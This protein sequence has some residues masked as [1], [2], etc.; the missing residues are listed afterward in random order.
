MPRML[1]ARRAVPRLPATR[2]PIDR[3]VWVVSRLQAGEPLN[4]TRV[5]ERF[6]ISP[7]TAYRDVEFL[8]DR[9][10]APIDYDARQ[11]SYVLTDKTFSL[12]L[13]DLSRGELLGLFF[14]ERVVRQYRGTP[15]EEDLRAALRKI[16]QCLPEQVTIDPNTLDGFLSLDLGPLAAPDPEV[17]KRVV[18]AASRGRRL[19]MTYTSLTRGKTAER[20]VDPYRVYNLRG[21][22]Y[23]AAFDPS[24]S[25]VRDFA[26]QR[27]HSPVV[28]DETFTVDPSFD[29]AAYMKDA[30][31]IEKGAKPIDV[32]VRFGPRQAR[33]IRER[34]WH[35]TARIQD[36]IDGG[37]VLRMQVAGL[38]EVRR[39]VMQFG[40][41]AEVLAPKSL[42]EA[43]AQE[44]RA[45]TRAYGTPAKQRPRR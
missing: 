24:H 40:A 16:E 36:R 34:R 29:F 3:I 18:E 38:G 32:A 14:A 33:W 22:W 44:L 1:R 35:P 12:P 25:A 2:P 8:R 45:A 39:W 20:T 11:R 37:C 42:R 6:E 13:A 4:A 31:S 19:R 5:A 7:R 15:Y 28:L 30:F 43:V 27:I 41:E 17:F 26:L 10:H 21:D 9:C 23:V